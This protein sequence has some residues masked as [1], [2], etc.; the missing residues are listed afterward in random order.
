MVT[1][2]KQYALMDRLV[3]AGNGYLQ[4]SAV[5]KHAIS[6]YTLKKYLKMRGMA[7]TVHG[8]YA[9]AEA[10]PDNYYLLALRNGRIV[11]S[12]ESALYLHGL[13]EREPAATTVTVPEGYN[14][15]HINRQG[16][17]VIH[18][19]PEWYTLGVT[20]VKTAYGNEV[21]VYDRERTI[22]DMIRCRKNV[23]VQTFRTAMR[24]YMGGEKKKLGNLMRYAKELEIEEKVRIYTEVML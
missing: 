15:T 16:I 21:P 5:R 9:T 12:H 23:E 24:E 13:M 8:V 18:S 7:R 14:S 22:C 10:W 17:R 20:K 2:M 4:V 19:K 11:F 3:E 6:N 1:D